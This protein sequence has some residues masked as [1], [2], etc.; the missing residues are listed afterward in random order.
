MGNYRVS[1][2]PLLAPPTAPQNRPPVPQVSR[3]AYVKS[4]RLGEEDVLNDGLRLRQ[5]PQ[6]ELVIVIGA[7]PATLEGRVVNDR[8]Q[9]VSAS[10][11]VLIPERGIRFHVDHKFVATD[12]LG[13]FRLEAIPPGDYKLF[14]WHD[15]E[16]GEWQ[17]PDFVRPHESR[18]MLMH[19][20]EGDRLSNVEVVSIPSRR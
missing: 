9:N 10:V 8:R 3:G 2:A 17:D 14:A 15:I 6:Q 13:R 7:N 19:I 12:T 20:K 4:I 5:Q 11:V 18:G 1:V 16:N